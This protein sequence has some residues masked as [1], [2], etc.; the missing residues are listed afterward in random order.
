MFISREGIISDATECEILSQLSHF[1]TKHMEAPN[2]I[3]SKKM[4][5]P[6]QIK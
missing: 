5:L 1:L 6:A 2:L 4:W 3:T